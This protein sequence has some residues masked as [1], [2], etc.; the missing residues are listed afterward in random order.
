MPIKNLVISGGGAIGFQYFGICKHLLESN[1]FQMENIKNIY[2]TSAGSFIAVTLLL[3][4]D[5]QTIQDYLVDRPWH[6]LFKF[7][8]FK[9]L[10]SFQTKGLFGS[11]HICE[12]LRPLLLGK[13]LEIDITLK[14]FYEFSKTTIHFNCVEFSNEEAVKKVT[15]THENFPDLKLSEAIQMTSCIPLL[16][17]PIFMDNK[18]LLDGGIITNYNSEE[19]L[20]VNCEDDCF[21]LNYR[22]NREKDETFKLSDDMNIF[23]FF[24]IY[25]FKM[26]Q[27]IH[28]NCPDCDLK[29]QILVNLDE[30]PLSS[31]LLQDI[32]SN[33]EVRKKWIQ[34]GIDDA[35]KYLESSI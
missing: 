15:I 1:F 28:K 6:E 35:K 33:K 32:F 24:Y 20:S 18:F 5:L 29:N 22:V 4:Y 12:F 8:P 19:C 25:N 3:N 16:I 14:Q 27:F 10:N 26:N 23:N 9:I 21:G 17:E 30:S 7:S 31:S 34:N 11:Y 2:C 13:N